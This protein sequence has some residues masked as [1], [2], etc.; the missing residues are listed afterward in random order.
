M[1]L[2]WLSGSVFCTLCKS[3]I[4]I[5]SSEVI[6][7]Y[8]RGLTVDWECSECGVVGVSRRWWCRLVCT[9][10][11]D[12]TRLQ[13]RLAPCCFVTTVHN[14]S[15]A[16]GSVVHTSSC[17]SRWCSYESSD[18][19]LFLSGLLM[20]CSLASKK[21]KAAHTWLVGFWSWSRFSAVSLQSH[22]PGSRLPLLSARPAVTLATFKRAATNFTAWWTETSWVW[23]VCLRLLP[24][25]VAAA[26]WTW[27]LLCLSPAR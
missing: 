3:C 6:L 4:K 16:T 11:S 22:K 19:F 8:Q 27:A 15:P 12:I 23:T 18:R 1:T 25:S 9:T 13:S 7:L 24:N 26:I 14:S 10:A 2:P 5:C 21:V 17:H 20:S